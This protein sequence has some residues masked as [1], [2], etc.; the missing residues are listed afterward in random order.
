MFNRH[1][2]LFESRELRTDFSNLYFF[3]PSLTDRSEN[4]NKPVDSVNLSK[5]DIK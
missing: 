3:L 2:L 4:I 5:I 1:R